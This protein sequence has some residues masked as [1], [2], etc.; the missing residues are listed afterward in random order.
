LSETIREPKAPV[1]NSCTSES[2]FIIIM[3]VINI[4]MMIK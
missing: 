2:V 3:I 4:P 1:R